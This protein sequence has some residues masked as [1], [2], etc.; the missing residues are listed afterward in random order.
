MLR[1]DV[2]VVF[3]AVGACVGLRVSARVV[4]GNAGVGMLVVRVVR[5]FR[6]VTGCSGGSGK[7]SNVH[8]IY[9]GNGAKCWGMIY[10]MRDVFRLI[11]G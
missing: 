6:G 10:A 7:M 11:G 5:N 8:G 2:R 3:C 9:A 1:W 4:C